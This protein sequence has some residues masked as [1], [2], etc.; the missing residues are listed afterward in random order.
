MCSIRNIW[1]R[2]LRPFR[3]HTGH[4]QA[5]LGASVTF[6][7]RTFGSTKRG[8]LA[9]LR[10]GHPAQTKSDGNV[11]PATNGFATTSHAFPKPRD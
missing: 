7:V 2:H 4:L 10:R 8:D 6:K 11:V 9:L 1:S 5:L 3:R